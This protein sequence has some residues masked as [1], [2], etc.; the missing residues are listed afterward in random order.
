MELPTSDACDSSDGVQWCPSC[1]MVGGSVDLLTSQHI[2]NLFLLHRSSSHESVFLLVFCD[3][4]RII[5]VRSYC[6]TILGGR[7][8]SMLDGPRKE[9]K[10]FHKPAIPFIPF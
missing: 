7:G 3:R 10:P 8:L 4:I 6:C 1:N 5:L 2:N 9:V